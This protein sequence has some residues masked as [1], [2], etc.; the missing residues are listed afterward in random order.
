MKNTIPNPNL[1]LEYALSDYSD[2]THSAFLVS[3]LHWAEQ[4][5]F[6]QPFVRLLSVPMKRVVYTPVQKVQTL[7]A[8]IMI[9]C[10]YNK[11][12]NFRL[13]PDQVAASA[14]GMARFPDQSQLNL[15]LR[16]M[17]ETN[18]LEL[19]AIHA[20]HLRQYERFSPSPS[21]EAEAEAGGRDYLLVDIDQ[22]GLIANG[23]TYELSRKGYFPHRRGERGYQMGAAWLGGSHGSQGGGI[24]MGLHLDPGNVHCAVRFR[25]LVQMS[26]ER[27]LRSSTRRS[28]VYR[29][30]GGYGTQ[31]QIRWM[32]ATNHLFIAKGAT[33]RPRKWADKVARE[34]W[35]RVDGSVRVA[36]VAGGPYV[37]AIVCEVTPPGVEGRVE[38]SVLLTN[39]SAH[40]F[41]AEALWHL[42]AGRQTIEAFFKMG[43]TVYG[44][45]NL[46]SRSFSAIY[47]FVW[48]VFITHNLLQWVRQ[49][50]FGGTPLE[51]IGTR[52]LVERIG[53]IPAWRQRTEGGWRLHL[54]AQDA[55]ARLFVQ[56]LCPHWVQPPLRLY[57]T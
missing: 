22:C 8:S 48:L 5:G 38:Y 26:D 21:A 57:E 44:L 52:E 11:D 3:A 54:P 33:T 41:D 29:V 6:W 53:R 42:Y 28:V 47:A 46:R 39:L 51:G 56:A 20:E 18:L 36:E 16:R 27:C 40:E 4:H 49:S 31:P 2:Y 7:M 37:R 35:Q 50:L 1:E 14:L 12:V 23:K 19:Q 13:V 9:G 10:K 55:L 25:E 45:G 15:L 24:T 30:D 32:V 17:D 43:R 34:Q